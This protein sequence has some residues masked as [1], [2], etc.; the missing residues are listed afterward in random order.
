MISHKFSSNSCADSITCIFKQKENPTLGTLLNVVNSWPTF[1]YS[2]STVQT[3]D[4]STCIVEQ[5]ENST[6]DTLLNEVYL[7]PE[8]NLYFLSHISE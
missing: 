5:R 6:L 1:F 7:W 8:Q 2:S 4:S 3:L